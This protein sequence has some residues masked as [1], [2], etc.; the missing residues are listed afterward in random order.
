M[1]SCSTK[2]AA[3]KC[4]R[5]ARASC[6]L[7]TRSWLCI[8][9]RVRPRTE[10]DLDVTC[11]EFIARERWIAAAL[12]PVDIDTDEPEEEVGAA[13]K[14]AAFLAA[15]AVGERRPIPVAKYSFEMGRAY[16]LGVESLY[17]CR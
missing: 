9:G 8:F 6:S 15:I 17:A 2:P 10:S 4:F 1:A 14:D 5:T 16:A 11:R 7:L 13:V 12:E 3:L